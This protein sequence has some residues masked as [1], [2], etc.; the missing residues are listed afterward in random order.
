MSSSV[1]AKRYA[2][3]L[4]QLAKEKNLLD[5]IEEE[6]RTIQTVLTD[7]PQFSTLLKSPKVSVEKKIET[8][9]TVFGGFHQYIQNTLMLLI[10]RRRGNVVLDVAEHFIHLANEEKGIADAEVY[11]VR[12]L[13]DEEEKALS[14]TFAEKVGKKQLRINNIVD[15][16]LLGGLKIRIGNRIYD[17]SLSGKLERLG[18]QLLG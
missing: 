16:D 2:L 8:V 14:E 17:G 1:V 12:P 13:T 6:L 4:F 7:N 15:T 3:A 9:K 11:S 18:R 10:E 5:Q